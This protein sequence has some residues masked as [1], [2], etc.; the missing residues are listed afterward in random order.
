MGALLGLLPDVDPPPGMSVAW[1]SLTVT[2]AE[3]DSRVVQLSSVSAKG[4][5]TG[6]PA[7]WCLG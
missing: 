4:A 6:V 5:S 7:L 1:Q 2:E 3:G